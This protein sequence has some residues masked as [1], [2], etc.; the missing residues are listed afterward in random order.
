MRFKKTP[1]AGL[2]AAACLAAT[3]LPAQALLVSLN[4]STTSVAVGGS[5][6]VDV[7]I[8]DLSVAGEIVSAYDLDILFDAA[9]LKATAASNNPAPWQDVPSDDPGF[10]A[11]ISSPGK[12]YISLLSFL[13]DAVL[14]GIQISDSITLATL[15]FEGVADGSTSISF[16]ASPQFQRNVIGL[17]AATLDASF[18]S[19]CIAVGTGN[20]NT[21]PEPAS[22]GLV[23]LA[24]AGMVP[25]LRRR[26]ARAAAT[27]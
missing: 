20:C 23:A 8:S 2:L 15:T 5:V 27:A 19:T 25:A 22:Y 16:G 4:P 26:P 17:D 7:V 12:V 13:D 21:V 10:V 6:N 3:T 9:V 18:G 14:A 24:L 11:D 1:F